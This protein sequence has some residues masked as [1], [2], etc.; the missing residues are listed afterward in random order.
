[1]Q[2]SPSK[3][4]VFQQDRAQFTNKWKAA[5]SRGIWTILPW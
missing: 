2:A 3:T 4:K 1:M 5:V